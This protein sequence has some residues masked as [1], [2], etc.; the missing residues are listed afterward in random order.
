MFAMMQTGMMAFLKWN[1]ILVVTTNILHL[2]LSNVR[3]CVAVSPGTSGS[4]TGT[5]SLI[6]YL[7]KLDGVSIIP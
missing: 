5:F 1:Q 7:V 6:V 2:F 4:S 3:Y